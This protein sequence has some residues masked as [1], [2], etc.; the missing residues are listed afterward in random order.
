M[1]ITNSAPR[2]E[3]PVSEYNLPSSL[4]EFADLHENPYKHLNV[5]LDYKTLRNAVKSDFCKLA[6]S[7]YG[8]DKALE[9]ESMLENSDYEAIEKELEGYDTE[10]DDRRLENEVLW[11]E[12]LTEDETGLGHDRRVHAD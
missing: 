12:G 7:M 1:S 3:D 11:L 8:E 2:T 9:L 4:E 6:R 10:I 5:S